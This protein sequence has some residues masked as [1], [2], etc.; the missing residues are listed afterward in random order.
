MTN[1]QHKI[2][3]LVRSK[4][5]SIDQEREKWT[6][7]V[8]H[9]N[10]DDPSVLEIST[11]INNALDQRQYELETIITLNNE[12]PSVSPSEHNHMVSKLSQMIDLNRRI[13]SE[14]LDLQQKH[15]DA[16][17]HASSLE[18]SIRTLRSQN[19]EY[20]TLKKHWQESWNIIGKESKS[21]T[22][23]NLNNL[24]QCLATK[25]QGRSNEEE[26]H[27]ECNM[28]R[29]ENNELKETLKKVIRRVREKLRD[30]QCP[31]CFDNPITAMLLPSK[32]YTCNG[33]ATRLYS[34]TK[35]D[36]FT[37]DRIE[38]IVPDALQYIPSPINPRRFSPVRR[39]L[40]Y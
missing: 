27:C 18:R 20:E 9:Y 35:I 14:N 1:V 36:P 34:T 37:R 7:L 23:E 8:N 33:C 2:S 15:K 17:K 29:N 6:D 13:V 31:I 39:G 5:S 38:R 32:L 10:C 28:L 12:S 40:D 21:P 3:H 19:Q 4:L 26:N 11:L 25:L 30:F 16:L 22:Q 24:T